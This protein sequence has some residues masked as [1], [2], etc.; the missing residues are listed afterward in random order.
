VLQV[1][2]ELLLEVPEAEVTAV[3]SLVR[4]E[5]C[6]AYDLDPPLQVDIGAGENWAEAKS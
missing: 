6:G 2:D 3:R 1:H 4:E 5:M